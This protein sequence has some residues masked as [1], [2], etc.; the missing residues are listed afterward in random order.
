[1][2]R[3]IYP[4][5]EEHSRNLSL[6]HRGKRLSQQA[7]TK[8][9]QKMQGNTNGFK[10][11]SVPWNKNKKRPEVSGERHWNWNPD[12]SG[13][14]KPVEKQA[15]AKFEAI[16]WANLVKRRDGSKCQLADDTCSEQL[17]AHHI[18]PWREH[19][20]LRFDLNNGITLCSR[21]HPH[22][23]KEEQ[24]LSPVF[25]RMVQNKLQ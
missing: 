18:L 11:G 3:G 2:A 22:G 6:A 16:N 17:D 1:M 13:V 15:R 7:R 20:A 25:Q 10:A 9:S 24:R 19:P 23:G 21:H 4:R 12:R 14:L 5:T 8:L